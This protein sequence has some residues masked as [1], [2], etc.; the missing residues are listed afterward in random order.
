MLTWLGFVLSEVV[1]DPGS[2][3][4][5]ALENVIG[6]SGFTALFWHSHLNPWLRGCECGLNRNFDVKMGLRFRSNL[7]LVSMDRKHSNR[8]YF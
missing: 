5:M 8:G 4:G 2:P 6:S 1:D 3:V 7:V